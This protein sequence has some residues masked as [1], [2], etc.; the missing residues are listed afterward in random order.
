[1]SPAAITCAPRI[2]ERATL[3]HNC[4]EALVKSTF[5][6][7]PETAALGENITGRWLRERSAGQ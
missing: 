2:V 1:M 7:V 5:K 4:A 3:S 6:V